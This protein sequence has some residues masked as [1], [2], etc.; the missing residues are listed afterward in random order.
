[1]IAESITTDLNSQF[2]ATLKGGIAMKGSVYHKWSACKLCRAGDKNTIKH[3]HHYIQVY[4]GYLSQKPFKLT[5][6]EKGKPF[7]DGI[8]AYIYLREIQQTIEEKA[9]IPWNYRK[10]VGSVCLFENF[11]RKFKADK[12][13]QAVNHLRPLFD[14]DLKDIDRITIKQFYR[15]LS[16]ELK[17]SSKNYMLQALHS[18]LSEAYQEGLIDYIPAFPRKDT[19]EKPAKFWLTWTEQMAIIDVLPERFKLLFLFLACHGKRV[20]EALSL[21][22]EDIDFRQKAVR[23]Y[24]SKVKTEQWLALHEEF[25]TALPFAGAIGKTGLIFEQH[26]NVTLNRVLM[27]ACKKAGVKKVTTHEMGRHSFI[28]QR[29]ASG[30][31]NEQIA[32]VTNNLSSIE[33]YSHMNLENKRKIINS[34]TPI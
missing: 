24:E 21:K 18:T 7:K 4:L 15:N 3:P 9:F 5:G 20:G 10:S 16:S 29:L 26:S 34:I 11:F 22:W 30:F 31:T 25:L 6:R 13:P 32:L 27:E 8:E 14:Y 33:K 12:Y 2:L 17:T 23:I 1:M 19:P 28:S